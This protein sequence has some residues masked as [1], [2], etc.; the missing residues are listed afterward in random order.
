MDGTRIP[1]V[2]LRLFKEQQESRSQS[3][4]RDFTMSLKSYT[5][6]CVFDLRDAYLLLDKLFR[7]TSLPDINK[8]TEGNVQ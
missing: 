4:R 6:I 5:Q 3:E 1:L 2:S 7:S 8:A